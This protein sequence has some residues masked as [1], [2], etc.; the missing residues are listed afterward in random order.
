MLDVDRRTARR[1]FSDLRVE[2]P[3][4]A[5]LVA[6]M[7]AERNKSRVLV[8]LLGWMGLLSAL[9]LLMG[10]WLYDYAAR[11]GFGAGGIAE[12]SLFDRVSLGLV[13]VRLV[14]SVVTGVMFLQWV[15]LVVRH[16]R[17]FGLYR[18]RA[19]RFDVE[20]A[21]WVWLIPIVNWF[22]PY[23]LMSS[24]SASS[25]PSVLPSPDLEERRALGSYRQAAWVRHRV[26]NPLPSVPLKRWWVL[27]LAARGAQRLM[28]NAEAYLEDAVSV[29][30]FAY[31]SLLD[32]ALWIA[33]AIAAVALV[34]AIHARRAEL[35]RRAEHWSRLVYQQ[36]A[37]P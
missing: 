36:P 10:T 23:A 16:A 33:A 1:A 25:D 30:R 15:R 4:P 3:D 29:R 13:W 6:A 32:G 5:E 35:H 18:S 28:F 26:E 11:A 7:R 9:E 19:L 34:R 24:V 22:R 37:S 17:R 2:A 8:G 20:S 21:T 31:V 14:S 12:A 27:F